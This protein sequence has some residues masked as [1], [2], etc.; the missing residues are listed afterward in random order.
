MKYTTLSELVSGVR[1]ARAVEVD[2]IKD[3]VNTDFIHATENAEASSHPKELQQF[4]IE[5]L[6]A[7]KSSTA[8]MILHRVIDMCS[9]HPLYKAPFQM[10]GTNE[11]RDML[12]K[13]PE[14]DILVLL[15]AT[16]TIIDRNNLADSIYE[17]S[18]LSIPAL[19]KLMPAVDESETINKNRLELFVFALD[20]FK[21]QRQTQK[22]EDYLKTA[23]TPKQHDDLL[24][25]I[26]EDICDED[27]EERLEDGSLTAGLIADG[28]EAFQEYTDFI[29]WSEWKPKD[30]NLEIFEALQYVYENLTPEI[31]KEN[32]EN[33]R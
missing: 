26:G 2:S 15:R 13:L 29:D 31:I 4:A 7:T 1:F 12:S 33:Y 20:Q 10:I 9:M 14:A 17:V 30:P 8:S 19:L 22:I 24:A 23:L 25:C 32:R 6:A 11:I 18:K 21:W 5:A 3:R 16:S 28:L 27:Y